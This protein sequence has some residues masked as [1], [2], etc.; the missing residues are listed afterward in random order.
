[1]NNE[2]KQETSL[3]LH[4]M[5]RSTVQ[6]LLARDPIPVV[7]VACGS[8]EQHGPHMAVGRDSYG[9]RDICER[10][11][12]QTGSIIL[13]PTWLGFSP[14]HMGVP[15]TVSLGWLTLLNVLIDTAKSLSHHGFRKI[16]YVNNHGGNKEII[17]LA[18]S[19]CRRELPDS[20][21]ITEPSFEA[22]HPLVRRKRRTYLDIHAGA[23]ETS[24]M[25]VVDPDLVD[26]DRLQDWEK[27][28]IPDELLELLDDPGDEYGFGFDIVKSYIPDTHK[29][30]STGIYG[31]CDPRELDLNAAR[32][33]IEERVNRI[34]KYITMWQS[35]P[36]ELL[37]WRGGGSTVARRS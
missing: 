28:Q 23:T 30:T 33:E 18:A 36:D 32:E 11:A 2:A 21:V 27:P 35:L 3:Y 26:M 16:M 14:H 34:A 4:N 13:H 29:Y 24:R 7:L 20:L 25:I 5:N 22:S 31:L 19:I 9:A 6:E 1:M 17:A 10:V 37:Q 15:G 8:V 12:K